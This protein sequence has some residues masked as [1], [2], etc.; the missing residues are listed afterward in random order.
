MAELSAKLTGLGVDHTAIDAKWFL[1]QGTNREEAFKKIIENAGKP[2]Q[3]LVINMQ[4]ARGVDIPLSD[5]AKALGGLHVRVTARSGLSRDIDIQAENRAARSGDAGSVSYY[6][7]P[8]D[9]AFALSHNPHVQLA[10]IQ[11]TQAQST[12]AV[13]RAATVLRNL[14]PVTQAESARRMGMYTPTRQP[15]A[16]PVPAI[17]AATVTTP[18]ALPPHPPPTASVPV[19]LGQRAVATPTGHY[20]PGT[21]PHE[22]VDPQALRAALSMHPVENATVLH[23]HTDPATGRFLAG[24]QLLGPDELQAGVLAQLGIGPGQALILVACGSGAVPTGAAAR[25]AVLAGTPVVAP[26]TTAVTTSSGTV[27]AA[28]T[29]V[30]GV[31][32]PV[33]RQGHWAVFGADG[34]QLAV[35]PA[36]LTSALR[37]GGVG[38]YLPGVGLA[39][40]ATGRPPERNITWNAGVNG[41]QAAAL[42]AEGYAVPD[43]LV[44]AGNQGSFYQA[45]IDAAGDSLRGTRGVVTPERVPPAGRGGVRQGHPPAQPALP[46]PHLR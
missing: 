5:D 34:A 21:G 36:D 18:A 25:L 3:V 37:H 26:T 35:L 14:V 38:Q 13:T 41:A 9:D 6:I 1:N 28:E 7:S 29:G 42:S 31:G 11:Y 27:L 16:P 24:G 23:L 46:A 20:L 8:R 30:D 33:V 2:G 10:V 45:L 32:L 22:A 44:A 43:G 19:S 17:A 39:L 12:E 15:N 40:G 4:G